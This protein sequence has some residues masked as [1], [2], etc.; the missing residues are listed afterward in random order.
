MKTNITFP[1]LGL[2][3]KFLPMETDPHAPND[4]SDERKFQILCIFD[5]DADLY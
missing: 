2:D 1:P 4:N 3:L 5:A